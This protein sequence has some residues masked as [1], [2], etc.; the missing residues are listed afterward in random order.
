MMGLLAKLIYNLTLGISHYVAAGL[1]ATLFKPRKGKNER[2]EEIQSL[3]QEE[4]PGSE[5]TT[6]SPKNNST[7]NTNHT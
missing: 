3:Q 6:N 2:K 1:K 5:E 4:R 7:R